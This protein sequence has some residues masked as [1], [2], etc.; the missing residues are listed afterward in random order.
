[1]TRSRVRSGAFTAS[2]VW[3]FFVP[4]LAAACFS[5]RGQ[6]SVAVQRPLCERVTPVVIPEGAPKASDVCF[7]SLTRRTPKPDSPYDTIKAMKAFHATRLEWTYGINAD[8]VRDVHALGCTIQGAAANGSVVVDRS[9][10]GWKN[11]VGCVDLNGDYVIAP[12]MRTWSSKPIYHCINNPEA[13]EGALAYFKK[14]IETGVDSIQHDATHLNHS[15]IAWGGCFCDHCMAGFNTWL[16]ENTTDAERR[17]EGI[18]DLTT[19]DYRQHLKSLDAPVGDAFRRWAGGGRLRDWFIQFQ[20]KA[21]TEYHR[22]WRQRLNEW[23]GRHIAASCNN[24]T[25]RFE[26]PEEMFDYFHGELQE[27]Y[28]NPPFLWDAFQKA[29]AMGKTQTVMMPQRRTFSQ[30]ESWTRHTRQTIAT[31]YALGGHC[32]VP[33]DQYMP[34]PDAKRYFGTPEQY[35][36]LYAFVRGCAAYLDGYAEAAVRGV[37]IHDSRWEGAIP[38]VLVDDPGVYAFVRAKPGMPDAPVAVHLVDWSIKPEAFRVQIAPAVFFRNRPVSL[39]LLTPAPYDR[40]A[41]ARAWEAREY[42]PLV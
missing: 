6:E 26:P 36:D 41:H 19:F 33:W 5:A 21:T 12:W 20:L 22:W 40:E 28:A 13:R 24:G 4:G 9:D 18:A 25:H 17:E 27:R 1:M 11:R 37:G 10:P 34:R 29:R 31:A 35:A 32:R 15:A 14:L 42:T 38:P 3:R 2:T 8:Y 39:K 23:A 7:R 16:R 30:F